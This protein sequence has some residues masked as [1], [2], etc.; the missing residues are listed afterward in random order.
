MDAWDHEGNAR[1]IYAEADAD[2]LDPPGPH[3]LARMLG[4]ILRFDCSRMIG[5][6]QLCVVAGRDTI[7]VRPGAGPIIEGARIYHEIAERHLRGSQDE[8][9][10]RACDELAYHLRMPRPAFQSLLSIVG[11]DLA[12]LAAPWPAS[13]TGAALRLLEV[14]GT[15]GVVVTPGDVRARGE[16]VWPPADEVRRLARAKRLPDGV[17]RIRITDRPGSAVLLAA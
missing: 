12:E 8:H 13:Q 3:G 4:I 10:E 11:E 16:W 5:G 14:T 1:S 17:T 6:A 9:L 2:P 15:P 7:F